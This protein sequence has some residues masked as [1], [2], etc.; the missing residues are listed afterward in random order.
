MV[1]VYR[2]SLLQS[3]EFLLRQRSHG[4]IHL[5]MPNVLAQERVVAELLGPYATPE[6]ISALAVE[7][8]LEPERILKLKERMNVLVESSLGKPGGVGRAASLLLEMIVSRQPKAH[9]EE[10][11]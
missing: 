2:G 1:I 9:L 3:L 7:M 10:E 8:L 4:I 11:G 6:A 5:G